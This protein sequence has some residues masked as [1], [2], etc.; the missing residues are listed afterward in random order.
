MLRM[1]IRPALSETLSARLRTLLGSKSIIA[2]L[3]VEEEREV[4]VFISFLLPG[5]RFVRR[6]GRFSRAILVATSLR[7]AGR[8]MDF[9]E[10]RFV[11][12]LGAD[13]IAELRDF[14]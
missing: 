6:P 12:A 13:R 1:S 4:V 8:A 3:P 9:L 2:L 14:A 5:L 7:S 11:R 10:A